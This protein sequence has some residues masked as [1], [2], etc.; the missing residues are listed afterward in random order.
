VGIPIAEVRAIDDHG[1][2]SSV[3]RP[4][5]LTGKAT[6]TITGGSL[7][8]DVGHASLSVAEI[9]QLDVLQRASPEV[10][11]GAE[12]LD[13][14]VRWVHISEQPDIADYLKGSEL[15]LTTLMGLG[16]GTALRR[17]FIRGL[18]RA[19]VAGL[20]VRLGE[21]F[22]F[23]PP[24]LVDEAARHRLPLVL[25]RRR[26]GFVEVTERVHGAIIS[27]QLE[28]LR[29]AE[30]VRSEFTDFVLQGV[31]LPRILQRLA[32]L[33]RNTV[34]LE[35]VAHQVVELA[36]FGLGPGDALSGWELHSRL[37][38]RTAMGG[39][40]Q[41]EVAEAGCAWV[42]IW[43]RSDLWG[44]VHVLQDGH[45]L[46]EVDLM[47]IDRAAAA[48]SLALLAEQ[49]ARS[50]TDQA[51]SALIRD[52]VSGRLAGPE[53]F[54]RR[55]DSLGMKL[56]GS[57][58]AVMAVEPLGLAQLVA[59][60]ELTERERQALRSAILEQTRMA[61]R[62]H[63][64][65]CLSG[66]DGDRLLVV[67]SM[68]ADANCGELIAKVGR[69]SCERIG[70]AWAGQIVPIV[71]ASDEVTPLLLRR[72]LAQAGEAADFGAWVSS[73]PGVYNYSD[74]GIYHLL[75]PLADGPRLA[76]YVEAEL[77]VLLEHDAHSRVALAPT[78]R[79][80][81]DHGGHVS[82]AAR[83][84]FIERRTLYHRIETISKLLGRDLGSAD[85][86]L[87]LSVALR[88]LDLLQTRRGADH[89]PMAGR[90]ARG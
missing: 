50:A 25:L 16:S 55:A 58:V 77:G 60:Q 78:L 26:I 63:G 80:F 33:V 6:T 44:R 74:L 79:S 61:I 32:D 45:M 67:L 8:E 4:V 27:H 56:S 65:S 10:L 38:H 49:D 89:G 31:G 88:A 12:N 11:A 29:R 72:A 40:V 54:V 81:L 15:L 52:I 22:P 42:P 46:D 85:T 1:P 68:P 66:I 30:K 87:R 37:P 24:E 64:L 14:L 73:S 59:T 75:L 3:G 82:A 35:D 86:R 21:E 2:R 13:R 43:L 28:L 48:V 39:K 34:V 69:D 17:D 18:A 57:T 70:R 36:P 23:V 19:R 84:L 5:G 47:A 62:S 71:G 53:E 20:L 90:Q 41:V 83:T 9:L 76:N 7:L 51:R